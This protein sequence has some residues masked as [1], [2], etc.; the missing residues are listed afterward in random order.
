MAGTSEGSKKGFQT[1][2]DKRGDKFITKRAVKGGSAKVT[3]GFA[4]RRELAA[5]AGRKGAEARWGKKPDQI[6][7]VQS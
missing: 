3:K 6:K 2:R 1:L 4:K 7:E 5:A